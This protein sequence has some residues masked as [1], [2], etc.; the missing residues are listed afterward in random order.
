GRALFLVGDRARLGARRARRTGS[1]AA[2][3]EHGAG[4]AHLRGKALYTRLEGERARWGVASWD[5]WG[6]SRAPDCGQGRLNACVQE[7]PD[8]GPPAPGCG[9]GAPERAPPAPGC[10]QET[11]DRAPSAP[12]CAQETP[13][14]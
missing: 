8:R 1:T 9:Q 13:D 10:A 12:G 3:G 6:A 11:P 5:A 4:P 14:R 2:R 7:A